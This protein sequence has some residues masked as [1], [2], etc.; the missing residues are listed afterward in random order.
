MKYSEFLYETKFTTSHCSHC[1]KIYCVTAPLSSPHCYKIY[2]VTASLLKYI[3]WQRDTEFTRHATRILMIPN[4]VVNENV[5][6]FDQREEYIHGPTNLKSCKNCT[7]KRDKEYIALQSERRNV[8]ILLLHSFKRQFSQPWPTTQDRID[9][10][11]KWISTAEFKMTTR[12]PT[13]TAR[14]SRDHMEM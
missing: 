8:R 4:T 14:H 9:G 7:Y 13:I 5:H 3:A 2:C 1:E 12:A 11:I 10:P 6:N